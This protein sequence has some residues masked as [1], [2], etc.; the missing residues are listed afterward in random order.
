MQKQEEKIKIE[1]GPKLIFSP[2]DEE[3][4]FGS[5]TPP[6]SIEPEFGLIAQP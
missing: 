5:P 6:K 3:K 1:N 4:L 2:A